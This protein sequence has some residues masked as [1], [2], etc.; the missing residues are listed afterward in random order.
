MTKY[1]VKFHA[2]IGRKKENVSIDD[3]GASLLSPIELTFYGVVEAEKREDVDSKI[4]LYGDPGFKI[5][6]VEVKELGDH[7]SGDEL[8]KLMPIEGKKKIIQDII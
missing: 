3:P 7:V 5:T 8:L 4:V 1:M 2:S 6:V